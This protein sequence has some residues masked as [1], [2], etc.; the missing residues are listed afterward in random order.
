MKKVEPNCAAPIGLPQGRTPSDDQL[1]PLEG[2][3]AD[4][5]LAEGRGD[6]H[7]RGGV[8]AVARGRR[9]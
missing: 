7:Q 9:S 6:E 4:E 1:G 3:H 5:H 8:D 2:L